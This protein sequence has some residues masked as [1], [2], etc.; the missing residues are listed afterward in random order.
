MDI[1]S[2][3]TIPTG[4]LSTP[5]FLTRLV[6][7]LRAEFDECFSPET[8]ALRNALLSLGLGLLL[9]ATGAIV[10]GTEASFA[11]IKFT[12]KASEVL[13]FTGLAVE[14]FFAVVYVARC[15]IEYAA[16]RVR[17]L[18]KNWALYELHADLKSREEAW[19]MNMSQL[20]AKVEAM[21]SAGDRSAEVMRL[22]EELKSLS[23]DPEAERYRELSELMTNAMKEA[24]SARRSRLII[25]AA[26]PAIFGAVAVAWVFW[27]SWCGL[28][29]QGDCISPQPD[30]VVEA[31]STAS[32]RTSPA[33]SRRSSPCAC[34]WSS[35]CPCRRPA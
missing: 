17:E 31:L 15:R 25:E 24:S 32:G 2:N 6:E 33:S 21:Y 29:P 18:P 35:G 9:L 10:F 8:K 4:P 26:F 1:E 13:L 16:W 23:R 14:V 28:T 30:P 5:E 27:S 12:P 11:G 20:R 7:A 22:S 19:L 34:A 3:T